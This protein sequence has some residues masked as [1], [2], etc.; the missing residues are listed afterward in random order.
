MKVRKKNTYRTPK[1]K[2]PKDGLSLYVKKFLLRAF[3]ALCII[4]VFSGLTLGLIA[5]YRWVTTC[6]FFTLQELNIEGNSYLSDRQIKNIANVWLGKNL[7]AMSVRQIED[8]LYKEPWIKGVLVKRKL[9]DALYIQVK[10]RKP[11]FW[12]QKSNT[13]YYADA[14]ARL[15][16]PVLA[17]KFRSL[18]LLRCDRES[19]RQKQCLEVMQ[20]CILTNSYPFGF[21][22]VGWI[23]FL[24]DEVVEFLLQD[25]EIKLKIG[26]EY[27]KSNLV[28]L[29][30]V[31]KD[32][33]Q[34]NELEDVDRIMVFEDMSWV[35]FK[36]M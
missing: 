1:D 19:Y 5:S 25:R 36:D 33:V 35:R 14:D 16:A 27:L 22:D 7:F 4:F 26:T 3:K 12:I 17:K 13:I 31:W 21:A 9:P 23:R 24:S 10:E 20:E 6:S 30:K 11:I 32:L 34:R 29:Q 15:I 2:A 8:R 28:Y 18:P